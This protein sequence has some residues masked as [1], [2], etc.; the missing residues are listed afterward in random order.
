MTDKN[1]KTVTLSQLFHTLK[2]DPSKMTLNSLDVHVSPTLPKLIFT[3]FTG[4]QHL[5]KI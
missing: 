1:G 2:M 4:R 3:S 5:S